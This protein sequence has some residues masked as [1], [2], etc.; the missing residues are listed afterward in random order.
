MGKHP[1]VVSRRD[2]FSSRS[3]HYKFYY[4]RNL[5]GLMVGR[6]IRISS[7]RLG[8]SGKPIALASREG[9][10]MYF[11]CPKAQTTYFAWKEQ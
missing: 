7:F 10:G 1:E 9:R 5:V 11:V 8:L 2:A 3:L 6:R 4:Y